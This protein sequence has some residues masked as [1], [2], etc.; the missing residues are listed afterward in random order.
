MGPNGSQMEPNG[1]QKELNGAQMELKWSSYGAQWSSNG[2]GGFKGG[3]ERVVIYKM[4]EW[5]V[6]D[7]GLIFNGCSIDV[8]ATYN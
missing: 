1:A 6:I 3:S 2:A 7:L 8:G 5:H 4:S